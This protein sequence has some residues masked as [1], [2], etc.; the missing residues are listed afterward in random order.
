MKKPT[1]K[2]VTVDVKKLKPHPQN[3]RTHGP[4][5]IAAIAQNIK[6]NGYNRPI[7]VNEHMV[8]LA[9]HGTLQ[10]VKQLGMKEAPVLLGAELLNLQEMGL[11]MG[12][13]GFDPQEIAKLLA[14]PATTDPNAE[15]PVP[16]HGPAIT[17]AGDAWI[18]GEHRLVCGDSTH[19]STYQRL[20]GG[21]LAQLVFTD[22]PYGVSY[23]ARSGQFEMI[24]GDDL[25]RGQLLTMLTKAFQAA[26]PHTAN[27]GAWYV[28]HASST[29]EDFATALRDTGLVEL[30]YLIWAKPQMVLG[31]SDY[32]WAHEPCFYAARQ[33][34]RPS[35]YG[36]GTDTTVWRTTALPGGQAA[37]TI[38]TGITLTT[39][40]GHEIHVSVSAPKGRKTRHIHVE[41]G[42]SVLLAAATEADD[43]WEVGRDNGHGQRNALHANQKPVELARRA[44]RNSTR[45]GEGVIDMFAGSGSTLIAAEQTGRAAFCVELDPQHCDTIVRRWCEFTGRD[46]THAETGKTYASLAKG[47]ARSRTAAV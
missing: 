44:I 2:L 7:M 27:D 17:T 47:K 42:Q 18:L 11:D 40:G 24:K 26:L 36:D 10:A 8:I 19:K 9:G 15:P 29:R 6:A 45:E 28:W 1:H 12:A 4:E 23:E 16:D 31:W 3:A 14:P 33:G 39:K 32:R 46:A 38:G 25:R 21:R 41:P 22:P 35:Y 30:G 34:V 5:Q 13:T 20:M 43:L 37:S